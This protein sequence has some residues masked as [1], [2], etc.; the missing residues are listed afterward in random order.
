[1]AHLNPKKP[2]RLREETG[3]EQI[4][5]VKAVPKKRSAQ[6]AHHRSRQNGGQQIPVPIYQDVEHQI[7]E[8]VFAIH[9]SASGTFDFKTRIQETMAATAAQENINILCDPTAADDLLERA[10]H[11]HLEYYQATAFALWCPF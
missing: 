6:T 5:A 7:R 10:N 2:T 3:V 9:F 8:R 11:T 4:V 1:M